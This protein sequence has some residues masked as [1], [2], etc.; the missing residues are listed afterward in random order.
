MEAP[1]NGVAQAVWR[2]HPGSPRT[3]VLGFGIDCPLVTPT[4]DCCIGSATIQRRT[5]ITGSENRIDKILIVIGAEVDSGTAS[6]TSNGRLE[7]KDSCCEVGLTALE[8]ERSE[9]IARLSWL[10]CWIV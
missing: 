8:R 7:I 4:L 1:P 2:H 6:W 9:D 3:P 5:A 10:P